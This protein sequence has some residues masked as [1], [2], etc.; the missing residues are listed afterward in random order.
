MSVIPSSPS[1]GVADSAALMGGGDSSVVAR[2]ADLPEFESAAPPAAKGALNQLFDVS[3]CVTAE[4]GR[5]TLSI[6]DILRLGPGAVVGLESNVA[7]PVDLLVQGVPFAR[8]EVV[9]IDD[10][11]AIRI[12]EIVDPKQVGKK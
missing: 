8:G 1:I 2:L 6:G 12:R 10:R 3:V 5:V 7:E 9:V 11:F 4:L